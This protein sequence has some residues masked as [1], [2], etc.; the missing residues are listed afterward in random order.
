MAGN[1]PKLERILRR[2]AT[3]LPEDMLKIMEVES[4]NFIKKNFRDQGF[5]DSGLDKWKPRKT[6][7]RKGRDITRYRTNRKGNAGDFTKFGRKNLKRAILVGH[8]TGGNKLKNS[9]RAR[10]SKLKVVIYTYKKYAERHNEGKDG[11]PVRRFFWKSKYLN[12]KIAEKAKKLLD[13]T[14]K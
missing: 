9:F 11:M 10:R 2:A 8:N 5:N 4:L 14:F 13:K 1:I 3:T 12:D 6:T 7:D